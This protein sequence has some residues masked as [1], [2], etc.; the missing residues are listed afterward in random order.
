MF[1]LYKSCH[2]H[3]V[4]VSLHSNGTQIKTVT[5]KFTYRK[6]GL[7]IWREVSF[8]L[9]LRTRTMADIHLSEIVA[10]I[11]SAPGLGIWL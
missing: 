1:F 10:I 8:D 11:I 3:M 7:F 6:C 2:G 5:S 9:S 4:M